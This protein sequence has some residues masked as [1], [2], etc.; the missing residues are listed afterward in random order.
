MLINVASL[1]LKGVPGVNM[2]E[3]PSFSDAKCMIRLFL[4]TAAVRCVC[5]CEILHLCSSW[6]FCW[7]SLDS[8][9]DIVCLKERIQKSQ[10]EREKREERL[11]QTQ[12][13]QQTGNLL[14]R[15]YAQTSWDF[16]THFWWLSRALNLGHMVWNLSLIS[17]PYWRTLCA[18]RPSP[19]LSSCLFLDMEEEEEMICLADPMR[20][21]T[22]PDFCYQE[23]A[24]REEDHFQVFR[25]QVRT[26][27]TSRWVLLSVYLYVCYGQR[28]YLFIIGWHQ[29]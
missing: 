28:K 14:G 6:H 21:I 27:C 8:S 16:L 10:E 22:D 1:W 9:C 13:L 29:Q 3:M 2:S 24:R 18:S 15:W 5:S 12:T 25:V 23:F 4:V 19:L 26:L 11:L 17:H 7:Q 20:F